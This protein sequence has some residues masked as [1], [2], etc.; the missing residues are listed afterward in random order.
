M[1]RY[2]PRIIFL[3]YYIKLKRM[4]FAESLNT[5]IFPWGF[6]FS[7]CCAAYGRFTP[8]L[9]SSFGVGALFQICLFSA[10]EGSPG[11]PQETQSVTGDM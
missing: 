3:T 1:G 6:I 11:Y 7:H 5:V 9:V 4:D 2:M 10:Q 8:G